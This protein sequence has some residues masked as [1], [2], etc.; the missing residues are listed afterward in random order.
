V[1][2]QLISVFRVRQ[3]EF[4]S[5]CELTNGLRN[6]LNVRVEGKSE[7]IGGETRI[8]RIRE[9]DTDLWESKGHNADNG[10]QPFSGGSL[11]ANRIPRLI[12]QIVQPMSIRA[13]AT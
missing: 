3:P 9:P 11:G 8:H 10:D 4:Q 5:L 12:V 6:L 13:S 2:D 7:T 1:Q